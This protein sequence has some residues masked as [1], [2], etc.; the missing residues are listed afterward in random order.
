MSVRELVAAAAIGAGLLGV[1]CETVSTDIAR[2]AA[3][4][5]VASPVNS[6]APDQKVASKPA[7]SETPAPAPEVAR[8]KGQISQMDI[9]TLF[10]LQGANEAFIID[11]RPAFFY[12]L[13]HIPGAISI[14]KKSFDSIYPSKRAELDA[15]ISAGK[16]IVLY[17]TDENCPDGRNTARLL[18]KEGYS[19][20]VYKGGWKEWKA[21]GL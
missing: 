21:S 13:D 4:A 3:P 14:P 20:S 9:G 17:C 5:P 12:N 2:P 6:V 15:A 7:P 8:A 18:A 1:S 16:V 11:V 10:Q 19:S